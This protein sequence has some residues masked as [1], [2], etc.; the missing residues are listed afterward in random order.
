M[1]STFDT[2]EIGEHRKLCRNQSGGV[3]GVLASLCSISQAQRVLIDVYDVMEPRDRIK[4]D[5]RFFLS[6]MSVCFTCE[7]ARLAQH[8]GT[9]KAIATQHSNR[10]IK[11]VVTSLLDPDTMTM[12]PTCNLT[13]LSQYDSHNSRS[14]GSDALS[15]LQNHSL[16]TCQ[17]PDQEAYKIKRVSGDYFDTVGPTYASKNVWSLCENV[18][19][20]LSGFDDKKYSLQM[21]AKIRT[22]GKEMINVCKK[23]QSDK[24]LLELL[25]QVSV[26]RESL[27]RLIF[28]QELFAMLKRNRNEDLDL[29][30]SKEGGVLHLTSIAIIENLYYLSG[31]ELELEEQRN[32]GCDDSDSRYQRAKALTFQKAYIELSSSLMVLMLR[33][34]MV[35]SNMKM[36]DLVRHQVI[37]ST[38]KGR[39][40]IRSTIESEALNFDLCLRRTS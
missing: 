18:G 33:E 16:L 9:C 32:I 17:D 7:L 2:N 38:F 39:L 19:Q 28:F 20:L 30:L 31:I 35:W 29:I 1:P 14:K 40:D 24:D 3:L 23:L 4:D 27:K 13:S 8:N 5:D 25:P 11:H 22:I 21:W 10:M 37:V 12:F 34:N 26:E 15:K 6:Q 36:C